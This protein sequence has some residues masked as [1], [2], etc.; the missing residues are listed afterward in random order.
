MSVFR[1]LVNRLKM[2][3]VHDGKPYSVKELMGMSDDELGRLYR[4]NGPG[5]P[6]RKHKIEYRSSIINCISE[7]V[8]GIMTLPIPIGL[9]FVPK[10]MLSSTFVAYLTLVLITLGPTL[11]DCSGSISSWY[12]EI[13]VRRAGF[14]AFED[15]AESG[16]GLPNLNDVID[17]R[18]DVDSRLS[19]FLHEVNK[20]IWFGKA[21]DSES[22]CPIYDYASDEEL[23]HLVKIVLPVMKLYHDDALNNGSF[24]ILDD[25]LS[26]F[27]GIRKFN[28]DVLPSMIDKMKK[29]K[30]D[31][32]EE[33]ISEKTKKQEQ[34]L[35]K[36]R[37]LNKDSIGIIESLLDSLN[38][39]NHKEKEILQK[40]TEFRKIKDLNKRLNEQKTKLDT[41]L[42]GQVQN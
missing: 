35:E 34:L 15:V 22:E 36:K 13:A 14:K 10:S 7:V 24:E 4:D 32:A 8:G 39:K 2:K 27:N 23:G 21:H 9:C 11:L 20:A 31:L 38:K 1:R 42:T 19:V 16:I 25:R 18:G 3:K 40:S 5:Q 12:E 37:K 30:T 41:S 33:E 28:D 26:L 17:Y 6:V 29:D